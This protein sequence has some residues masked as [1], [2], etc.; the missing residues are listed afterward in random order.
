MKSKNIKNL[1]LSTKFSL[2]EISLLLC[3]TTN[4]FAY[5]N[6]YYLHKTSQFKLLSTN[7][8]AKIV[9]LGDSI[10]ERALWGELSSRCDVINR[11]ISGDTTLGVL[12]R[13]DSLN[14]SL[15]KAF[16]MIGVNDIFKGKSIEYIFNNY[17]KIITTLKKKNI[18]PI[19]QSTLYLGNNA[20]KNYNK[21]IKELNRLLVSYASKNK[22]TFIDLNT[23][24]SPH[25]FLSDRYSLDSVHLNAKGYSIWIKEIKLH[26]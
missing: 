25:G 17:K 23:K 15:E 2:A 11:G 4:L 26:K 8:Q 7:K 19:I 5:S 9:M 13:L 3:L 18:T 10:S 21:K 1:I 24:L 16:V 14:S 22:I 12:N 20:P 6:T